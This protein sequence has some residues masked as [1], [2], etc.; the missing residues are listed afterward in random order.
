[1]KNFIYGIIFTISALFA[2]WFV[3][4]FFEVVI[5]NC[6]LTPITYC[7]INFFEIFSH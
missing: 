2:I 4:S 7:P 3:G 1:M 6:S 5:K